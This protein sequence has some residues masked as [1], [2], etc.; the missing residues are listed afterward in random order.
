MSTDP[1]QRIRIRLWAVLGLIAL[2]PRLAGAFLLQNP[3]GDAY[4]YVEATARLRDSIL[5][6]NFSIKDLA[7]FWLP[8]YQLICATVSTVTG[9]P[10]YTAKLVTAILGAGSCFLVFAIC[11][12]ITD[13]PRLAYWGFG[14]VAANPFHIMYSSFSM[15]DVPFCFFVLA[16]VLLSIVDRQVLAA[17]CATVAGLMR[18]EAWMLIPLI[19]ALQLVARRKVSVWAMAILM[20]APIL[21]LWI[22][23]SATGNPF[24]YFA[25]RSLYVKDLLVSEPH[26]QVFTFSRIAGDLGRLLYA[27]NPME[28]VAAV[29]ASASL[30]R[31]LRRGGSNG[32][33]QVRGLIRGLRQTGHLSA[34]LR[35]IVMPLACFLAFLGFILAAYW[36]NNQ[37]QIWPRYGLLPFLLGIPILAWTVDRLS[38]RQAGNLL[39]GRRG[40]LRGL[41]ALTI[42]ACVFQWGVQLRDVIRHFQRTAAPRAVVDYCSGVRT[43]RAASPEG[44]SSDS[45]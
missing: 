30:A 27:V 34:E 12:R 17:A 45:R 7:G 28:L 19:P 13:K 24:D 1:T 21:C 38:Q 16:S 9:H 32:G 29:V 11:R 5:S 37:P 43:L 14:I 6:G 4:A 25:V 23:K 3:D 2:L 26:L 8:G 39:Y 33:G 40:L 10:L 20:L 31:S 42:A 18:V 41:A 36:T 35:G 44:R 22:Y 15:T